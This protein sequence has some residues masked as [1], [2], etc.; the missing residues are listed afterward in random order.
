MTEYWQYNRG[1]EWRKWDL[2]IHTPKTKLSDNYVQVGD[3]DIWKTYCTKIEESDVEVL[4]ITDYFSVENYFTFIEKHKQYFPLSK[5][6]F[7]PNVELR[8]EVSVNK[9]AEEVNIHVIFSNSVTITKNK[10]EDF[11]SLVSLKIC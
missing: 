4:G 3:E 5:K 9:S 8:L 7:F 2:H 1:S 6:V 11:L 10:I